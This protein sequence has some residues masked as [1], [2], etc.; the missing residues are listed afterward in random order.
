AVNL[1]NEVAGH[2]AG[3]VGGSA[4]KRAKDEELA[5]AWIDVEANAD[6]AE[7][8]ARLLAEL[9][10][11]VRADEAG[12]WVEPFEAAIDHVFDQLAHLV[13]IKFANVFLFHLV[14]DVDEELEVLVFSL[15]IDLLH[16]R[17]VGDRD[18]ED[19]RRG[20]ADEPSEVP[21]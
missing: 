14:E 11:I 13:L 4:G 3:L 10:V 2:D 6:A 21:A 9:L 20:D 15:E 19:R 5:G 18:A 16:R 7:L 12:M 8:A 17:A 1:D